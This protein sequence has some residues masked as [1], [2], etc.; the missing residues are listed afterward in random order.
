MVGGISNIMKQIKFFVSKKKYLKNIYHLNKIDLFLGKLTFSKE[1]RELYKRIENHSKNCL[2]SYYI[3]KKEI[4]ILLF[5]HKNEKEAID[6]LIHE[7]LHKA[8]GK[9][10]EK[11]NEKTEH[12]LI[13][14]LI[15]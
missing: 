13:K 11:L 2:G 5:N 9:C 6:T 4:R 8:I 7:Y 1:T 14:R 15:K 12:K 3:P 10:K